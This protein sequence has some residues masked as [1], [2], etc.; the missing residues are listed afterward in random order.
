MLLYQVATGVAMGRGDGG[1]GGVHHHHQSCGRR[2]IYF[3]AIA[4]SI[5]CMEI[6]AQPCWR[7]NSSQSHGYVYFCSLVGLSYLLHMPP[8]KTS[9]GKQGLLVHLYF[10]CK[11]LRLKTGQRYCLVKARTFVPLHLQSKFTILMEI[12]RNKSFLFGSLDIAL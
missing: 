8:T 6:I 9:H 10:P 12:V 2:R 3:V 1:R 7:N 11:N 5:Q 4:H